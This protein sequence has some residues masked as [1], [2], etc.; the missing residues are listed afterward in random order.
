MHLLYCFYLRFWGNELGF[1][2][3][4]KG[5]PHS[6]IRRSG[7]QCSGNAIASPISCLSPL[8]KVGQGWWNLFD[9]YVIGGSIDC[10]VIVKDVPECDCFIP[11]SIKW[12]WGCSQ[13][14]WLVLYGYWCCC[15][16]WVWWTS[17]GWLVCFW[18]WCWWRRS[19]RQC[20]SFGVSSWWWLCWELSCGGYRG[21][22]CRSWRTAGRLGPGRWYRSG[23]LSF[24]HQWCRNLMD[25]CGWKLG[26]SRK[27]T[28]FRQGWICQTGGSWMTW[29]FLDC[30]C[31]SGFS[32]SKKIFNLSCIFVWFWILFFASRF[33]FFQV[34]SGVCSFCGSLVEMY[35]PIV[36]IFPNLC[37]T[38]LGN[39]LSIVFCKSGIDVKISKVVK[40]GNW[41]FKG[42][43][44]YG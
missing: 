15:C 17:S 28:C 22:L 16:W 9:I 4:F 44:C 12:F 21:G 14:A 25:F 32:S 41:C 11:I 35:C 8:L 36:T 1:E 18:S 20:C 40:V 29:K 42:F 39:G 27:Q 19:R 24:G 23:L 38:M 37:R 6:I 34:K 33:F 10:E 30:W 5:L 43:L 31:N 26:L 13:D 2:G 7:C 3:I